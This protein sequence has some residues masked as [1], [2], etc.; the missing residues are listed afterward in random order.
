MFVKM[1]RT[2]TTNGKD[3]LIAQFP[4]FEE[5]VLVDHSIEIER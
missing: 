2:L 3:L 4:A 1:Y 5:A